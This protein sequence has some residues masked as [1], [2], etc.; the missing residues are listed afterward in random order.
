MKKKHAVRFG[1]SSSG[2]VNITTSISEDFPT[3]PSGGSRPGK[4]RLR[5]GFAAIA[6][7]ALDDGDFYNQ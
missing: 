7:S 2:S 4:S 3:N 5:E 1:R 6:I